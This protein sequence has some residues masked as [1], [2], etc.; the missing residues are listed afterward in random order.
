MTMHKFPLLPSLASVGL[1]CFAGLVGTACKGA[2]PT[3]AEPSATAPVQGSSTSTAATAPAPSGSGS[4]SASGSAA[5]LSVPPSVPAAGDSTAAARRGSDVFAVRM[6]R[7]MPP[8]SNLF[9]SPE[10]IRIAL[11]MAYAGARGETAKEMAQVLGESGPPGALHA[12]IGSELAAFA[13]QE[14]PR[15]PA[16]SDTWVVDSYARRAQTLRVVS[17]LWGQKGKAFLP[18]FLSVLDSSYAAPLEQLDF[19]GDLEGSRGAINRWVDGKTEHKIPELIAKGALSGAS[20]LVLTNAVYFKAAWSVPFVAG[21]TTDAPFAVYPTRSVTTKMMRQVG[22]FKYARIDQADVIEL[23]YA[24]GTTSMLVVVPIASSGLAAIEAKIDDRSLSRWAGAVS[25]KKVDF[26][27]PR[28]KMSS[29]FSLRDQLVALG[30]KSAFE[31]PK[32]DFSGMDGTRELFISDVIHK[33]FIATDEAGTEAAAA[34][35]VLMAAGAAPMRVD[36]IVVR[37]DHPFLIVI[38]EI[39]TGALLFIGR[40]ANPTQ[41]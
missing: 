29:G 33:A 38:R 17:R 13:A 7:G 19:A 16:G 8:S 6:L 2:A 14:S 22:H 35:A 31:F 11:A 9:F 24:S 10:S 20:R 27:L 34:T 4:P 23:P 28:F 40:V 30:M 21:N 26:S 39:S 1:A 3:G 18:E 37:A 5:A 25:P 36:P 15:A 41:N 12:S 32:A